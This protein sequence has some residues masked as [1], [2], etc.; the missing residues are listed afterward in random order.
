MSSV[1][2]EIEYQLATLETE[3]EW[4]RTVVDDLRT[5]RLPWSGEWLRQFSEQ[6]MAAPDGE[7]QAMT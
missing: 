3:L 1:L 5:D 2:L 6:H 4:V 7:E